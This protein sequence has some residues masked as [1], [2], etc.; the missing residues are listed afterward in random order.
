MVEC[1][2]RDVH[3]G[4]P[5]VHRQ[6]RTGDG[7]G[8]WRAEK[9]DADGDFFGGRRAAKGHI[10]GDMGVGRVAC[11]QVR[12]Q[13]HHRRIKVGRGCG[14]PFGVISFQNGTKAVATGVGDVKAAKAIYG[15]GNGGLSIPCFGGISGQYRAAHGF[16]H[17]LKRL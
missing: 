15:K 11:G 3:D 17:T 13:Q 4:R 2:R 14:L 5:A 1:K 16:G 7:G 6:H 10:F 12:A 9:R 8:L